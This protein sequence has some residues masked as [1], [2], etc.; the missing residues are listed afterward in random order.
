MANYHG[1]L[2]QSDTIGSISPL[3]SSAFIT[4]SNDK[5]ISVWMVTDERELQQLYKFH[6]DEMVTCTMYYEMAAFRG[7]LVVFL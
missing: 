4:A 5:S 3:N 7:C 1:H 2:Q 6:L